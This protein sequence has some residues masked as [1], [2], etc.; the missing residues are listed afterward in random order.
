MRK[1]RA[2]CK[3]KNIQILTAVLHKNAIYIFYTH[4]CSIGRKPFTLLPYP[5]S[6][7]CVEQRDIAETFA[8]STSVFPANYT[9]IHSFTFDTI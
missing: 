7:I 5:T 8:P 9:S 3:L 1:F 6:G 4:H 2:V